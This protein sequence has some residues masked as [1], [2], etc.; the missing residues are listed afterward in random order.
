MAECNLLNF[1][2]F[3]EFD[4]GNL[5]VPYDRSIPVEGFFGPVTPSFTSELFKEGILL[6]FPYSDAA[7]L[8]EV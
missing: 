2:N 8:Q 6:G 3:I 4:P 5:S 7:R 1:P